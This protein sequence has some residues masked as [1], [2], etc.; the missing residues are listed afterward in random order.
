MSKKAAQKTEK[1]KKVAIKPPVPLQPKKS[2]KKSEKVK[3][4]PKKSKK[5]LKARS[6]SV[7]LSVSPSD[8]IAEYLMERGR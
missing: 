1:V 6:P 2:A 8:R 3:K 5:T 4:A 7:S